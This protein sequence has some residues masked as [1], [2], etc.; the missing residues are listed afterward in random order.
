MRPEAADIP[1]VRPDRQT[2]GA[3][4]RHRVEQRLLVLGQH[5]AQV[6]LGA[7]AAPVRR[8]H[9]RQLH[10]RDDGGVG[11]LHRRGDFTGRVRGSLD[12]VVEAVVDGHLDGVLGQQVLQSRAG[13][14]QARGHDAAAGGC[15]QGRL[16]RVPQVTADVAG[17]RLHLQAQEDPTVSAHQGRPGQRQH[18]RQRDVTR[19]VGGEHQPGR[20]RRDDLAQGDPLGL[21]GAPREGPG[22]QAPVLAG[23]LAVAGLVAL[24]AA[25]RARLARPDDRHGPRVS[26]GRR[27]TGGA[28]GRAAAGADRGL[29]GR[30]RDGADGREQRTAAR[31]GALPRG[32]AC[33]RHEAPRMR[34]EQ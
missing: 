11:P 10:R 24:A 4:P 14:G 20:R 26:G 31:A 19:R 5:P 25:A 28:R 32:P 9:R 30:W 12:P 23:A 17:A 21:V 3:Q 16:E 7:H 6:G 34:T 2:R 29:L 15:G 1:R 8:R 18:R 27:G 13:A 22:H 33:S